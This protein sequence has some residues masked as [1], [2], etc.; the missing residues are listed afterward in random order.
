MYHSRYLNQT[1]ILVNGTPPIEKT[2]LK[3]VFFISFY[4]NWT[5][6]TIDAWPQQTAVLESWWET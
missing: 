6:A 1:T 3:G 5:E 2:L 4:C